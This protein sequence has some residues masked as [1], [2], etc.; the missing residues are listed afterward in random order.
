MKHAAILVLILVASTSTQALAQTRKGSTQR[1]PTASA[2]KAAAEKAAA[3]RRA[4]ADRIV[5]QISTV[6]NFLYVYG[7]VVNGIKTSEQKAT[8]RTL[9]PE[10]Q[11]L[12]DKNKAAVVDSLHNLGDG[13][14]R[15]EMDFSEDPDLRTYY[16]HVNKLYEDVEL[17]ANAAEQGNYDDAGKRLVAVVESLARA[18][19]ANGQ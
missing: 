2:A 19:T 7:S 15:M 1:R 14:R 10:T 8:K 18:L 12:I 4:A 5:T 16:E 13:I 6:S 11:A 3:S 17:A 9:P